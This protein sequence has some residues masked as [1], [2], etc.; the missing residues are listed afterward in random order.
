VAITDEHPSANWKSCVGKLTVGSNPTLS[1]RKVL[2][3]G[4]AKVTG[5]GDPG[6]PVEGLTTNLTTI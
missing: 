2:V 6:G 5:N 4:S 1:A 3:R